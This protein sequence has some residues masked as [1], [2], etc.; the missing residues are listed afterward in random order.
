[1]IFFDI[2][3]NI[4]I[5]P[6]EF[7]IEIVFYLF[8]NV[9]K[10]GYAASLFFLSLVINFISL[11]LY[12]IAE[13][14]QK[15]ERDIQNKMKPMIDNIK[16][17][18]KG[19]Q[20][21]LLIR[22][23]QRINGYKTIYAFRGTLGLLI[24]IPFFL[25]AYNF[26][27]NLSGLQLGSF[28]F[29]K[30]FSKPDAILN[31]GNISVNILPFI[32]T[33]FSLLAGLVYSKKLR[34]KESLPLYIVSLIFL[35]L[36]YNSPSGL[37]F[38]WTLNCLFSLIK[39]IVIE[40]KLYK[41]FVANKYKIL[42]GYNIFFVVLTII[43]LLLVSLSQMDRKGYVD[44]IDY[45]Y[46]MN[47]NYVYNAKFVPYSKIFKQ[48]DLFILKIRKEKIPDYV[49]DIKYSNFANIINSIELN[50]SIE[51]IGKVELHYSLYIRETL[52]NIYLAI[53]F[54][55]ILVNLSSIENFIFKYNNETKE[56]FIKIRNKLFLISL[57]V[58]SAL[59]GFFIPC[60]L[61]SSSPIEFEYPFSLILNNLSI[62]LG[63]FLFYPLFI[64]I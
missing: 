50:D 32:M 30:D 22:A 26:I 48:S 57:L 9:F 45:V 23:C 37:V 2:L 15:K 34:F 24:Q 54:I 58:I 51:N 42:A 8:N 31:I 3:Y 5:Y 64:Y 1:M 16:A 17:V 25:A 52:I 47:G 10:S 12:N 61:I 60:Q 59:S 53:L 11:P 6:I 7:I 19:D 18:Y 55:F 29:I 40:Y 13:S 44:I 28:L 35:V 21:Y 56:Q 39:N 62:S 20:R 63:I 43:F 36:L 41:I 4:I 49:I 14:W 46:N 27:H 33:L 38:Y